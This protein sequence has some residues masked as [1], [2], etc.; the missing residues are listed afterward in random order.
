MHVLKVLIN[1]KK[2]FLNNFPNS[3]LTYLRFA[4]R[5]SSLHPSHSPKFPPWWV[6]RD[7]HSPLLISEKVN[8]AKR[9]IYWKWGGRWGQQSEWGPDQRVGIFPLSLYMYVYIHV[10]VC[11][12]FMLMYGR[13]QYDQT[14]DQWM[15]ATWSVH[16]KQRDQCMISHVIS[17][18][19]DKWSV[20][21]SHLISAW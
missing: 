6:R 9:G 14:S 15:S 10:Y 11:G 17:V 21:V 7:V 20:N 12:W 8:L 1:Q 2:C 4:S 13:N 19:S 16:D 18:W 5:C 3:I